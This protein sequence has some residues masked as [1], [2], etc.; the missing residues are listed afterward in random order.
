MRM[1]RQLTQEQLC[2][3]AGISRDA[4]SR[5]ENGSRTPSLGTLERI[6][7]ALGVSWIDVLGDAPRVIA[8]FSPPISRV[9]AMLESQP[10]EKQ[11]VAEALVRAYL[12]V[13]GT[14]EGAKREDTAERAAEQPAPYSSPTGRP[15]RRSG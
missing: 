3:L 10:A 14:R 5:I 15:R 7:G 4:V 1:S 2:D 9:I 6:I 8:R 13:D 12:R 11:R